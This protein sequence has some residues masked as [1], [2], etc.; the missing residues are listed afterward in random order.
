MK[1]IGSKI[2]IISGELLS[3]MGLFPIVLIYPGKLWTATAYWNYVFSSRSEFLWK[4]ALIILCIGILISFMIKHNN[5]MKILTFSVFGVIMSFLTAFV[6]IN[7]LAPSLWIMLYPISIA[8][9][10]TAIVYT[11]KARIE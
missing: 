7:R 10:I 2:I 8:S 6:E 3:I 9:F 1:D 11:L 4:L 5:R